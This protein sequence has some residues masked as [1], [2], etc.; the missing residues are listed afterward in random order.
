MSDWHELTAY[1]ETAASLRD[2]VRHLEIDHAALDRKLSRCD[3][4]A[5]HGTCCH[6]GVYLGDDEAALIPELVDTCGEQFESF[7]LELPEAVIIEGNWRGQF[8]GP[9]TA[10]RPEPMAELVEE[11]PTHFPDTICVFLTAEGHCGLQRLAKD[12]AHHPWYFK[13][14]TCWLHPLAIMRRKDAAPLLTIHDRT[15]DPQTFPGYEGFASQTHCGRLDD[16]GEPASKV[17][18]SEL[19]MLGRIGGRDLLGEIRSHQLESF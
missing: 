9:K 4:A 6:D 13:P 2:L 1:P 7:G 3:L 17:L 8:S 5:C 14:A 11:Y 19:H 10:T 16:C 12:R 15:T 18:A